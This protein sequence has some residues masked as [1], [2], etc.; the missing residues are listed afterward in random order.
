M[1]KLLNLPRWLLLTSLVTAT[2]VACGDDDD[3]DDSNAGGASSAGRG[4]TSAGRGGTSAG[5]GGSISGGSSVGGNDTGDAGNGGEAVGGSNGGEAGNAGAG[6]AAEAGAGGMAGAGGGATAALQDAQILL[7]LDTLN[8]GEV[9]EAYAALPRLSVPAVQAFA[10]QMVMDHSTARQSVVS[11]ANS[12]QLNPTPSDVQLN[13]KQE[14][15]TH[16]AMLRG[17]AAANLDRAYIEM[18]VAAHADALALLNDL[19]ATADAEALRTFIGTLETAVQAHY[20]QA[21][22]IEGA[23]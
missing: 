5:R 17:T 3:D 12:L 11:A 22:T 16:V 7:V 9:E 20:N 6:G 10:Q 2:A 13:L 23:L 4:G 1:I 21:V 19:E 18:Q 15:E 8:Q 14:A